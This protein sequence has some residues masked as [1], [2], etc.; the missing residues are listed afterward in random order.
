MGLLS[1]NPAS[2]ATPPS[3]PA[4]DINPPEPHELAKLFGLATETEV[5][6]ADFIVLAATTG[7]RRSEL[8]ALRWTDLD[9]DRAT[10]WIRRG[11]V[12]GFTGLVEKDT[13]NHATR[14]VSLDPTTMAALAARR[15]RAVER[16]RACEHELDARRLR[17][18]QRGRRLEVVVP[19]L[20]QPRLRPPLPHGR[21]QGH[22]C[23]TSATSLPPGCCLLALTCAP[24]PGG[25]ATATQRR[26]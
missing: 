15:D 20:C 4:P 8:V 14:R 18:Q 19:G 16:A 22:V 10:V 3:V 9:L 2:S 25:S 12:T 17:V 6:L 7:A 11:I 23:M 13:K 5:D 21:D 1:V 26:R 24:S